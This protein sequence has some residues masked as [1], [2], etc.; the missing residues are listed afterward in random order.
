MIAGA[1]TG[2][3]EEVVVEWSGWSLEI[4]AGAMPAHFYNTIR[5]LN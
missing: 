5:H 2:K 1:A 3:E 4:A